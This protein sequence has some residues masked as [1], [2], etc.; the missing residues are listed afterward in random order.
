MSNKLRTALIF[1]SCSA[2]GCASS[3]G[4]GGRTET[5]ESVH[6]ATTGVFAKLSTIVEADPVVTPL[7]ASPEGAWAQ[8]APAYTEIGIPL[9]IVAG[10][11]RLAGNQGWTLRRAVGGVALRNYLR[12]GDDGTGPNADTYQIS[13]NVATQIQKE[14]DGTSSAATVMDAT[15]SPMSIGSNILR[16]S[17]TG[18]LEKRINETIAKRLNLR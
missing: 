12:C 13:M 9:T 2:L 15:A 1:L 6:G 3:P 17:S 8:V 14:A 18:E 5:T 11:S 16:C 4:L 7:A 10:D